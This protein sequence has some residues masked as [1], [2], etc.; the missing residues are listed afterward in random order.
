MSVYP[1]FL[2]GGEEEE[3]LNSCV[4]FLWETMEAN[5]YLPTHC[6]GTMEIVIPIFWEL[7]HLKSN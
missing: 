1:F 7:R 4:P 2:G 5:V 6:K 3:A